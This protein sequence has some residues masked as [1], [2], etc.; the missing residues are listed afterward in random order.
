MGKEIEMLEN[1]AHFL[2][3]PVDI[4]PRVGDVGS[5]K[6][7]GAGSGELQKIQRTQEGGFSAS[8]R[9]DDDGYFAA[10]DIGGDTVQCLDG[11]FIVIFFEILDTDNHIGCSYVLLIHTRNSF[12]QRSLRRNFFSNSATRRVRMMTMSK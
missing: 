12:S 6:E 3:M 8:G 9:T 5:V 1:H 10:A 4:D 2:A 11:T 7:N